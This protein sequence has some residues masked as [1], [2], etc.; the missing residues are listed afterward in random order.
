MIAN[1]TPIILFGALVVL[2]IILGGQAMDTA[3]AS[4]K[5]NEK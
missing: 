2:A 1:L 3:V 4:R 5:M